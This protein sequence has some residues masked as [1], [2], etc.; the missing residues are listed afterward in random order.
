MPDI[1]DFKTY[2]LDI[3]RLLF[4]PF[5]AVVLHQLTALDPDGAKPFVMPIDPLRM[6]LGVHTILQREHGDKS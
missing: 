4:P 2:L 1:D 3:G 6:H 5:V